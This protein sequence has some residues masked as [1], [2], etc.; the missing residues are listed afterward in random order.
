MGGLMGKFLVVW[1]KPEEIMAKKI[2]T[3]A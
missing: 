2:K 3:D 1:R